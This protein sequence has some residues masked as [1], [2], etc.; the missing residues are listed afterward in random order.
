MVGIGT[1]KKGFTITEILVATAILSILA[2]ATLPLAK[3]AVKRNKEIQ[4]RRNLRLI[5]NA[6]DAFKKLADDMKFEIESDT[7]G[8][9]PNLEIMVEGIETKEE[10]DG[11]EITKLIKLLR[12]IPRDPF[13]NTYDWGL[14]SYQD[15]YDTDYWGGENVFDIYTKFLG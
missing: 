11:E 4:L 3:V 7:E 13:T 9:P 12:R 10:K 14:R 8:Y 1:R 2:A 6:V 15:D 5:R